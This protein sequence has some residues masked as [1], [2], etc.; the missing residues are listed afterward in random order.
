M[1]MQPGGEKRCPPFAEI[2][3]FRLET[4]GVSRQR[5]LAHREDRRRAETM[6]NLGLNSLFSF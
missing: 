2:G 3:G 4:G 5:S 6:M 1:V